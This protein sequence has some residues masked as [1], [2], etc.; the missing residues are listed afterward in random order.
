MVD[1]SKLPSHLKCGLGLNTNRT[2]ALTTAPDTSAR[3][4]V[5]GTRGG[6]WKCSEMDT[7]LIIRPDL[8][9]DPFHVAAALGPKRRSGDVCYSAAVNGQA[10]ISR[11]DR[12]RRF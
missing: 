4:P 3:L 8:R 9:S 10:D 5:V 11:T 1:E 2:S 7:P 12:D 6:E